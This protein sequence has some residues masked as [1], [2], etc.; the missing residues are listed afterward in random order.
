[1]YLHKL[2]KDEKQAFL[3]FARHLAQVDDAQID[4]REEYMLRSRY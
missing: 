3:S 1:M 2:E 4:E